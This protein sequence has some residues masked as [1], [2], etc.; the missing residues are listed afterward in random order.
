FLSAQD[1]RLASANVGSQGG[2]VAL[3]RGEAHFA[4]SHLLDPKTGEYNISY[5]RQYMP[6]IPVKVVALVG[7]EQGLIVRKGNPKGIKGL[8]D[9][10]RPDV[11]FVNRQRGA[12]T[13]VLLDYHLKLMSTPQSSIEGYQQEEYTHLGVAAAVASGRADC[14]LGIAA[15]AQALDLEFI[16]LF[17]ERYDLVIPKQFAEGDLLAPLFGLLAD[18][19]FRK[20]V[21]QLPGYDVSVMGTVILED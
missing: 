18:P 7:R 16:P 15:A 13:R 4:G 3:R 11:Q 20:A 8:G 6:N 17:Q 10:S 14:G 9:L 1:R 21:S 12:G 19:A 2:L 5:I